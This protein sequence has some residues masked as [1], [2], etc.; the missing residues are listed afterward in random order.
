MTTDFL[1]LDF[2]T[3]DG[4]TAATRLDLALRGLPH[5]D[6]SLAGTLGIH[7]VHGRAARHGE[8]PIEVFLSA[9][10][11]APVVVSWDW[12]EIE[13]DDFRFAVRT[14]A[15]VHEF[16]STCEDGMH[17]LLD[18]EPHVGDVHPIDTFASARA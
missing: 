10:C 13:H 15:W 17:P 7:G 6:G 18:G 11:G 9:Q 1:P 8:N 14:P 16:W 12:I 4:P 5:D 3:H 2:L